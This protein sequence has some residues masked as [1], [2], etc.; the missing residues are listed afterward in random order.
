MPLVQKISDQLKRAMYGD[1]WHGP[2]VLETL[3]GVSAD[4]A[5]SKHIEN[6]HSI[7]EITLHITAWFRIVALRLE[8]KDPEVT[9]DID[10]PAINDSSAKA[11]TAAIADLKR[12]HKEYQRVADTIGERELFVELQGRGFDLY[13]LYHGMI[14][15]CLYH[16]GQIAIL[17]KAL[18]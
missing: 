11:W 14:Q 16:A 4:Q 1:A 5:A 12:A 18:A 8:G 9:R 10:W 2:S 17:K 15:H 3:E 13:H 7:W 6:A